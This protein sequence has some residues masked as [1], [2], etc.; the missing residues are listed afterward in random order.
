MLPALIDSYVNEKILNF[1]NASARGGRH[2]YIKVTGVC[3]THQIKGL[4][5]TTFLQKRGSQGDRSK[6]WGV[7][8]CEIAQDLGI[9]YNN[10]MILL[11]KC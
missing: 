10:F 8:W 5:V 2:S 4:S 7:I 9:G 3:L 1:T 6:K 11:E